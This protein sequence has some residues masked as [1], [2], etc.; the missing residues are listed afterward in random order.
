MKIF[1]TVN[2]V[3]L[4]HKDLKSE[5]G[6]L[7]K[8]KAVELA[9]KFD[10]NLIKLLLDNK[11]TKNQFF[12]DVANTT[13]FDKDSF[14][15]FISNKEFLPDSYTAF[16][17]KIGLMIG[18]TYLSENKDVVLSWPYKDCVLEG[19]MT[20]ED[21]KR[22]EIFYNQ[23]LA[24]D[25]IDR[26]LDPKVFTNLKRIDKDGEHP[27][28]EFKRDE[29][30]NI[31]D[32]LIIKSNNL[33]A[34]ASLQKEFTG[35][36]KLIYIDPPYYFHENKSEDAFAYNSNFKLSTWLVFMKNRLEISK[37]LLREDGAIF[38]QIDDDGLP[39]LKALLDEMYGIDNCITAIAVKVTSESGVKVNAN[40]PVRVKETILCYSKTNNWKYN[41]QV[42]VDG[43]YD[44]NYSYFVQN[45]K[46]TPEK[47]KIKRIKEKIAE[48]DKNNNPS[49]KE[50]Y[51]FQIKFKDNIF[52]IRDISQS[53]KDKYFKSDKDHFVTIKGEDKTTILYKNGEVVFFSNKVRNIEGKDISIK[54]LSDIWT[55]ISW[56]GI[57][58]EG[59]VTL[60]K[61]K[62]PER[63]LARIIEMTTNNKDIVLDYHAGSG[64]TCAV[65]HKIGRQYIGI[66]QL[67]YSQNN[68]EERLI[69]VIN[70]DPTGISKIVNWKGGGDFIYMEF[71]KLNEKWIDDIKK[72]KTEKELSKIWQ[73]MQNS[74]YLSHNVD[75]QKINEK[76]KEFADLSISDQK[77][78]L[79]ECLDQNQ[80][81]VNYSEIDD[82]EYGVSKEDKKLN[83]EFYESQD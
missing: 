71:A 35:K 30:G 73:E 16:K 74:A 5:D 42:V 20:K 58:G 65:A 13:I 1:E 22:D 37:K 39:Y 18:D 48:L 26:L 9:H 11:E 52:S 21:Q 36:V 76:A 2:L 79:I 45:P 34:L 50:L 51:N 10:E 31:K 15:K 66:E 19:G 29:K 78:F 75:I 56:D 62:K 12:K 55:D 8:N 6:K 80:L 57:A 27:L 23:T 4:K 61:G 54:H 77:K 3:L 63:L 28:K 7:L 40:K 53:L 32:N 43:K 47:W 38:I 49:E 33:L 82:K 59:G 81:Y 41:R 24:P 46:D 64:T 14:V 72:T 67:D 68:P 60:K 17:N 69:N 83:K 44:Q 70:G 25:E